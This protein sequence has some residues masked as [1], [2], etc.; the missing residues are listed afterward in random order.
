M[1]QKRC[2]FV[3][4]ILMPFVVFSLDAPNYLHEQL[5]VNKL[6]TLSKKENT[7]N[8]PK[9]KTVI[10]RFQQNSQQIE[11]KGSCREFQT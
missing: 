11:N 6:S 3:S 7:F 4:L 1:P 10:E 9:Q 5:F 8:H 2:Y